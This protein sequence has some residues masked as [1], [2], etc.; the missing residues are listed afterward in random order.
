MIS[1]RASLRICVESNLPL[2]K[3]W[4]KTCKRGTENLGPCDHW[5]RALFALHSAMQH[6]KRGGNDFSKGLK[7]K[8]PLPFLWAA[9][10]P[11]PPCPAGSLL[12]LFQLLLYAQDVCLCLFQKRR[13]IY[14]GWGGKEIRQ[15]CS[16]ALKS[17]GRVCS[18][19]LSPVGSVSLENS[20]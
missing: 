8:K 13:G 14:Y 4:L 6:L 16:C 9:A 17:F 7:M 15:R 2:G 10:C 12:S 20:L 5:E 18:A 11:M 19:G 3:V 1:I